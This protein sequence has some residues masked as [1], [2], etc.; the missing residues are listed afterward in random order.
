ME[1]EENGHLRVHAVVRADTTFQGAHANI[2][3][4]LGLETAAVRGGA[5]ELVSAHTVPGWI[6]RPLI[7]QWQCLF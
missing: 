7:S 4:A 3:V 6:V 2:F 5:D 1:V